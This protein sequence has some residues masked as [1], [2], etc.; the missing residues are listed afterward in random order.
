[1]V[2]VLG[3]DMEIGNFLFGNSRGAIP[4][5]R[6]VGWEEQLA[7]LFEVA[8]LDAFGV[9]LDGSS[10]DTKAS[11]ENDEF[12]VMPYY[13][14]GCTCGWDDVCASVGAQVQHRPDCIATQIE[15]IGGMRPGQEDEWLARLKRLYEAHGFSTEG[16]GWWH[17]C[18]YRCTCDYGERYRRALDQYKTGEYHGEH[19]PDCLLVRDNFH[20][21]PTGFGI[22]WYKTPLRSAYMNQELTLDQFKAIVD[23]CIAS[24]QLADTGYKR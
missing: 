15:A 5:P 10:W 23:Q 20:H 11:Y 19:R 14:G 3:G 8:G 9:P 6:H 4:I 17:G 16:D 12:W 7:R 21:K 22:Q 24:V 18:A 2:G 1:M 13:W